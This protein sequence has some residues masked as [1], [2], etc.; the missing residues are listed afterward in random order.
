[1]FSTGCGFAVL[2]N[3]P[4]R[5]KISSSSNHCFFKSPDIGI[6]ILTEYQI[7]PKAH[8]YISN[9]RIASHLKTIESLDPSKGSPH[10]SFSENEENAT[11]L[12]SG[13]SIPFSSS[14]LAASSARSMLSF[15]LPGI[16]M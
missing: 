7:I 6:R 13:G 11:A 4:N 14:I 16:G 1:M 3:P 10:P 15:P 12:V 9:L 8:K 5:S 2:K